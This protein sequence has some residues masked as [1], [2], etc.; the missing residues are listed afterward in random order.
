MERVELDRAT[1]LAALEANAASIADFARTPAGELYREPDLWW[2]ATGRRVPW[3][4]GVVWARLDPARAD[5]RIEELLAWFAVRGL[6]MSWWLDSETTRPADLGERLLARGLTLARELPVMIADLARVDGS[7]APIPGVRIVRL[8]DAG[9]FARWRC[10]FPPGAPPDEAMN[11]LADLYQALGFG[12]GRPWQH[13]VA[14][15]G[16]EPLA[17][18][19]LFLAGAW[20]C[21]AG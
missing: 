12:D 17:V 14:I 13:Y 7:P 15:R 20:R 16:Q 10:G 9:D 6:P 3:L 8:E 18:A 11:M 2:F 4:N 5:A 19:S 1:V 21:C